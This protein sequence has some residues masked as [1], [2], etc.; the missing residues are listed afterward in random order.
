MGW[1]DQLQARTGQLWWWYS[2]R[3]VGDAVRGK[4]LR[5]LFNIILLLDSFVNVLSS[6]AVEHIALE[7]IF[8]DFESLQVLNPVK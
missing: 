4:A 7:Q 3:S 1:I 2:R 8:R 5:L 6:S